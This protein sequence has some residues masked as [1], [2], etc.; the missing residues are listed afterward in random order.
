MVIAV[1]GTLKAG[2]AYVPIDPSL[3]ASRI[4]FM[5][6]DARPAVVITTQSL[7][8]Q[9]SESQATQVL[10]LDSEDPEEQYG[11]QNGCTVDGQNLAYVIYT[12]GSTGQP[13]GV[14]ISHSALMN[15]LHS[16][17]QQPGFTAQ[18]SLLAVTSLSF[19]IAGLELY[20]PLLTGGRLVMA[21][22]Q[23]AADAHLLMQAMTTHRTT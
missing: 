23:T 15:F 14:A 13:K 5:L 1:L 20:L 22:R 11:E 3:P 21:S 18:D 8:S 19:D 17:Q 6:Q 10:F 2:G 12:S 4:A 9:I 7:R 16:V